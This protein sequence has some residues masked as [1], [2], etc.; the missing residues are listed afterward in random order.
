MCVLHTIGS[1]NRGGAEVMLA[2]MTPRFRAR[3]VSRCADR[4]AEPSRTCMSEAQCQLVASCLFSGKLLSRYDILHLYLFPAQFWQGLPERKQR[5]GPCTGDR[6]RRCPFPFTKSGSNR[7]TLL[8]IDHLTTL[9]HEMNQGRVL[10]SEAIRH[11][12][13]VDGYVQLYDPVL[14]V[15]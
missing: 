14:T 2:V 4:R 5:G 8:G 15:S 1:L 11:R 6:G 9:R 3:R 7:R 13:Y 10:T 12:T